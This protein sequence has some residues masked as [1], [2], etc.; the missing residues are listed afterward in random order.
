[1]PSEPQQVGDDQQKRMRRALRSM[2]SCNKLLP[3]QRGHQQSQAVVTLVI[4]PPKNAQECFSM[5]HFFNDNFGAWFRSRDLR[6]MGP[7][8][9]RCATPNQV[10]ACAQIAI[11]HKIDRLLQCAHLLSHRQ[12]KTLML[13]Y[14]P[15]CML[16]ACSH[17]KSPTCKSRCH[18][19]A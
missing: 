5:H 12:Y 14:T 11:Q 3:T 17:C 4:L 7:P 13:R 18:V 8:R 19:S 9:F 15:G 16:H 2:A 10:F 1:M 6:V